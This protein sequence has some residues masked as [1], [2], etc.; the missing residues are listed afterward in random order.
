MHPALEALFEAERARYGAVL[1]AVRGAAEECRPAPAGTYIYGS[2]ARGEDGPGSDLDIIVVAG[3]E[4]E[5]AGLAGAMRDALQA[6]GERLGFQASVIGLSLGDLRRA[7]GDEQSPW[8]AA[9][10]DALVV[11]GKE[12]AA[13]ARVHSARVRAAKRHGFAA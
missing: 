5:V 8:R 1:D 13:L 4:D 10:Q 9:L 12:P 2:V 6:P 11:T 7:T 3:E